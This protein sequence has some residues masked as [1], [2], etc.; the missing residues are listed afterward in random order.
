MDFLNQCRAFFERF[1]C[2]PDRRDRLGS[3][4]LVWLFYMGAAGA[5]AFHHE[6]WF[7]EAQ[8]WLIARDLN[9]GELIGHFI[10]YEGTPPLWHLLLMLPAKA[11]LPYA[12]LQILSI[13]LMGAGVWLLLRHSPF[14]LGFKILLPFTFFCFYQ[15]T[16]VARSYALI[17]PFLGGM[18]L[19]HPSRW[20]KPIPFML[21]ILAFCW[22]SLHTALLAGGVALVEMAT[23]RRTWKTLDFSQR[24]RRLL[25][26][27]A[28]AA[29][30][31]LIAAVVFPPLDC[32]FPNEPPSW[33]LFLKNNIITVNQSVAGWVP[34]SFAVLLALWHFFG[35]ARLRPLYAV[36]VILLLL[37]F[38]LRYVNVWHE[39][40]LVF[41]LLFVLWISLNPETPLQENPRRLPWI[42]SL[43]LL[44]MSLIQISWSVNTAVY[45][46]KHPYSGSRRA[47]EI[48]KPLLAE[49][50]TVAAYGFAAHAVL[51]YFNTNPFSNSPDS[52]HSFYS[53]TPS[54]IPQ[55]VPPAI[56]SHADLILVA[57]KKNREWPK[58]L[59][60][61]YRL[62]ARC[63]GGLYWKHLT[64]EPDI[65]LIWEKKPLTN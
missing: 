31:G 60:P 52:R 18:A 5:V 43:A 55:K 51:P 3:L 39:G 59:P 33:A 37:L 62:L 38:G 58:E 42:A 35:Q 49:G 21:L 63:D 56:N 65:Y 23:A 8:A 40:I 6:P 34:L 41:W 26:L 10:R 11:G 7:D 29:N 16:V 24:K 13:A 45:D 64:L 12:S 47:A 46:W 15:Y 54:A 1:F 57:I 30:A 36:P 50:K 19:A 20:T 28:F 17:L 53:W 32:T 61:G 9:P 48:L 4:A 14:P 27:A 25:C 22:I 2:R 44:L